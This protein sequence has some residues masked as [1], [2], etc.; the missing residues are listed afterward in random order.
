MI[1]KNT[2]GTEDWKMVLR[3]T[4]R[5]LECKVSFKLESQLVKF[6][7]CWVQGEKR[8]LIEVCYVVSGNKSL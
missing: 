6:W 7:I 4:M 5:Q 2:L 3:E 1:A 8:P